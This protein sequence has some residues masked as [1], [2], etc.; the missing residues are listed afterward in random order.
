[1]ALAFALLLLLLLLPSGR[2][3]ALAREKKK[4]RGEN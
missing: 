3:A 4:E 1:L 2:L